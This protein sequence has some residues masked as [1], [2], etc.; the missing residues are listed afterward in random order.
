VIGQDLGAD[1]GQ[2]S[3]ITNSANEFD[4]VW[5]RCKTTQLAS[6]TAIDSLECDEQACSLTPGY[7]GYRLRLIIAIAN[8]DGVAV[9]VS[10]PTAPVL[11]T[12]G[13]KARHR[14]AIRAS[15]PDG[16]ERPA[17]RPR[18]VACDSG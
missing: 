16:D 14:E 11:S 4:P 1:Y 3:L 15:K 13:L 2:Y 8:P 6:C 17:R 10:A 18:G 7:A 9:G 5:Y 12:A